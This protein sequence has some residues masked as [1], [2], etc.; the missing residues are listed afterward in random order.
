MPF[1]GFGGYL[2][3]WGIFVLDTP[4]KTSIFGHLKV[5]ADQL[6]QGEGCGRASDLSEGQG[7]MP[8][9]ENHVLLKVKVD[10]LTTLAQFT[11]SC[12]LI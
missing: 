12:I 9:M 3:C 2:C 4:P 8:Y 6:T 11:F 5:K 1:H 10:H 7:H